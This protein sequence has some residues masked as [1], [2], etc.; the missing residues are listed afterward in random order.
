MSLILTLG[1]ILFSLSSFYFL[2]KPK[3][4]LNSPFLVSITTLISYIVMLE[5]SFLV[6]GL[7]TGLYW[8]RWAFYGVSCPLLIYEISKQVGLNAK[9]N[10]TNIFL[11]V[12][13]MVTG[14]L[15]SIS[16]AEFKLAFFL[17]SSI[18]FG[19]IL[20]S[21][22][23][24]QSDQLRR[25]GLYMILGWS[26][27]PVVFL[28]SFEGYEIIKNPLAA[29]IYLALDLFTKIIFYIHYMYQLKADQSK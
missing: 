13:V 17:I 18:I 28:L 9:Q 2:I 19:K 4:G 3:S 10:F 27:F 6:G 15:S 16:E 7:D 21:V 20:H 24:S 26:A 11:T 1:I 29:S 12:L 5:G 8:T 22:F 14:V 23:T 25:I